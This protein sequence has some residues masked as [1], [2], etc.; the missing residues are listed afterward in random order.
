MTRLFCQPCAAVSERWVTVHPIAA[1]ACAA[2]GHR[3]GL[4]GVR[5]T[6]PE[7]GALRMTDGA[8]LSAGVPWRCPCCVGKGQIEDRLRRRTQ[9]CWLG[10]RIACLA[11]AGSGLVWADR[12]VVTGEER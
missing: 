6:H 10:H 11:C 9:G 1:G 5:K 2:C 4:Y 12:D 7:A 3:G 8:S